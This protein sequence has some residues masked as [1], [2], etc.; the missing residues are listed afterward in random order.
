MTKLGEDEG[1]V[2]LTLGG[3]DIVVVFEDPAEVS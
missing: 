3:C 1:Q 2:R